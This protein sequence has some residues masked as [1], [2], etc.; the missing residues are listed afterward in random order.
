MFR[1][2][3]RSPGGTINS[4]YG[5]YF[6]YL[7]YSKSKLVEQIEQAEQS[8]KNKGLWR[9]TWLEQA[10]HEPGT[11]LLAAHANLL[12]GAFPCDPPGTNC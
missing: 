11:S 9:S 8:A 4:V 12:F 1:L 5:G 6:H 3:H 2:Y 10:H 7:G